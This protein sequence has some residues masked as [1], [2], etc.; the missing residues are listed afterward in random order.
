MSD[1]T[2]DQQDLIAY[3]LERARETLRDAELL[4]DQ[5][6]MNRAYYAMFYTVL[7][8]LKIIL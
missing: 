6:G 8:L 3:R 1:K 7:A 2:F 5:G 4:F